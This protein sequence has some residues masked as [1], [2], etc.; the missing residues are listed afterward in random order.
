MIDPNDIES[1]FLQFSFS[2][3][4]VRLRVAKEPL[5]LRDP[6]FR[7]GAARAFPTAKALGRTEKIIA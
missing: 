4:R 7:P 2:F 5:R 3:F 6:G 1:D